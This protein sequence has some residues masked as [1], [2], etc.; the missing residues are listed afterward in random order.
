MGR[1]KKGFKK[2]EVGF[3][4]SY[5][6]KNL[7]T[8]NWPSHETQ[9]AALTDYN[10]RPTVGRYAHDEVTRWCNQWLSDMQ[11]QRLKN[12]RRIHGATDKN[13]Q[14]FPKGFNYPTM[15]GK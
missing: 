1:K 8:K 3:V 12:T 14:S 5:I 10:Q 13:P 15:P 6:E 2:E 4:R 7:T 11:W 9:Q